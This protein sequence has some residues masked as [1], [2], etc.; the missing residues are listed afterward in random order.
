ME[1]DDSEQITRWIQEI[2][3]LE[4]VMALLGEKSKALR[5][6]VKD[7]MVRHDWRVMRGTGTVG[8]EETRY[9]AQVVRR[10]RAT[11][12]AERL[13]GML[14]PPLFQRIVTY[15]VD[16]Q[17]VDQ[18]VGTGE[19]SMDVVEAACKTVEEDV[20]LQIRK[21]KESIGDGGTA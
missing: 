18:L 2:M 7:W 13:R 4:H 9:A 6:K 1:K 19:L 15:R 17:K 14:P 8:G 11:Y 10:V 5:Q 3:E 16:N 21:E 20:V 12:D